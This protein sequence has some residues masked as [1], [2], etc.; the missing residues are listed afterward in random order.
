MFTR[1]FWDNVILVF[2]HADLEFALDSDELPPPGEEYAKSIA[3]AFNL[4]HPLP[5]CYASIGRN[6]GRR[7]A[8]DTR[9]M[10]DMGKQN[11]TDYMDTLL[12]LIQ[13][14]E[15]APYTPE[16]FHH[17]VQV[18]GKTRAFDY[19]TNV[20]VP[21]ALQVETLVMNRKDSPKSPRLLHAYPNS[22]ERS[23]SLSNL[24]DYAR[25]NREPPMMRRDVAKRT[26]PPSIY[27]WA[28]PKKDMESDGS[29]CL[30]S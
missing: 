27:S 30:I 5:Y 20:V 15:Q 19:A 10:D 6:R 18:H 28:S 17:Y 25:S 16:H 21:H 7:L 9:T 26:R 3:T 23:A 8:A 22:H 1:R 11:Q 2:T 13:S 4:P 24:P 14:F 29:K 12:E